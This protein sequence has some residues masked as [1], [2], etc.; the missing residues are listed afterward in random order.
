[1]GWDGVLDGYRLV[2]LL[3]RDYLIWKDEEFCF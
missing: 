2:L 1:M 3:I